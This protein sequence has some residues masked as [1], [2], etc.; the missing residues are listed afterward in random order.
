[1]NGPTSRHSKQHLAYTLGHAS[2]RMSVLDC[3]KYIE[4]LWVSNGRTLIRSPWCAMDGCMQRIFVDDL[5]NH[6]WEMMGLVQRDFLSP[7]N[8]AE[9]CTCMHVPSKTNPAASLNQHDPFHSQAIWN[10]CMNLMQLLEVPRC[11]F[12]IFITS[13][14]NIHWLCIMD[15]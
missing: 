9:L 3:P 8:R 2:T 11:G 13:C 15:L 1:M 6:K 14:N 4:P 7:M 12:C 10:Q 5:T